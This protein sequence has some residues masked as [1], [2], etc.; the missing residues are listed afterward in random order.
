MTLNSR[1]F[2]GKAEGIKSHELS[3]KS[4][5]E[6]LEE[7]FSR[8][9]LR[10]DFIEKKLISM[11]AQLSAAQNNTNGDG[12]H[13]YGLIASIENQIDQ[14]EKSLD[15]IE[16][17]ID[18]TSEEL[19]KAEKEFLQIEEEKKQILFEI[20]QRARTISRNISKT[21]GMYG[22]YADI[23]TSL[24]QSFQQSLNA[25]AQA[26]AILD[27]VV[28]ASGGSSGADKSLNRDNSS[29]IEMRNRR[30]IEGSTAS[31]L[32]ANSLAMRNSDM[33]SG[34]DSIQKSTTYYK[35]SKKQ[36]FISDGNS[37]NKKNF[38]L[39]SAQTSWKKDN[40]GL[41]KEIEKGK[42]AATATT[43]QKKTY[44]SS[45]KASNMIT[46]RFQSKRMVSEQDSF[47]TLDNKLQSNI[48]R[49]VPMVARHGRNA[50]HD[51]LI[52]QDWELGKYC[53]SSISA[54]R[55]N[56]AKADY[57][58]YIRNPTD[59]EHI[60]YDTKSMLYIDPSTINGI[61]GIDDPYFWSYKNTSYSEYIDMAM[62]IPLVYSLCKSGKKLTELKKRE[63]I[64]GACVRNYFLNNDITVMRVGNGYI[65][66]G[67][68]RHRIMA[69]LIVGVNIPVHLTDEFIKKDS[70]PINKKFQID[71][72]NKRNSKYKEEIKA[73][74]IPKKIANANKKELENIV[75]NE[76]IARN[77]DLGKI[78]INIA[79]E[80]I[81]TIWSVKIKYPFLEFPYIGSTQAINKKLEKKIEYYLTKLYIQNDS[82]ESSVDEIIWRAKCEAK[83]YI[84]ENFE[85]QNNDF[86][87][88]NISSVAKKI[89]KP[90][91]GMEYAG[92]ITEYIGDT[93]AVEFNGININEQVAKNYNKLRQ[94]LIEQEQCGASPKGCDTI[95]YL[96]MHEIAH[97]LDKILQIS[98][99]NTITNKY[100]EFRKMSLEGKIDNLCLYAEKDIGEFIA[101][102][103]AE[104]QCSSAPRDIAK[105][106]EEKM[107]LA[108]KMY[109]RKKKD[110]D[111]RQ[112]ELGH[113]K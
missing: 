54:L 38:K 100:N 40:S 25:L 93:I 31:I 14:E 64:V 85:V 73:I 57:E 66:G 56:G 94:E 98:K 43:I 77:I 16:L 46:S 11:Y 18:K 103:W 76:R 109:L 3:L 108:I 104:S 42:M 44:I 78:D 101:E 99:D 67:E 6:N 19:D 17:E 27:G 34:L 107:K 92:Y 87:F 30:L 106:V 113:Q 10:K 29:Q 79:R 82:T 8:L 13:N 86:A 22:V 69:A 24:T 102:A 74:T 110:D 58:A 88:S 33:D 97:H 95:R 5:I 105:L 83:F 48:G 2:V 47:R 41:F 45:G 59:Y 36:Y 112:R 49:A 15:S 62:Q 70:L 32:G 20:Q 52:V 53:N 65:F 89:K 84:K 1:K 7:K 60:S 96:V 90:K 35:V 72:Q 75:K 37:R 111:V 23:G 51:S 68:G 21:S 81:N 26:A 28:E 55:K 50:F 12:E 9:D 91:S 61:R 63:D 71:N 4:S 39:N 80:V